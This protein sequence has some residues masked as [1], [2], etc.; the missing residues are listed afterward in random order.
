[1]L[2]NRAQESK[3]SVGWCML[4][5]SIAT[6]NTWSGIFDFM[7]VSFGSFSPGI[8][9]H[10]LSKKYEMNNNGP[11][12]SLECTGKSKPCLCLRM[13]LVVAVL[14]GSRQ[15]PSFFRRFDTMPGPAS[16][17]HAT[18]GRSGSGVGVGQERRPLWGCL[19]QVWLGFGELCI[20]QMC[21]ELSR[22]LLLVV[23]C[24]SVLLASPFCDHWGMITILP[25][26][27]C[28]AQLLTLWAQKRTT[29]LAPNNNDTM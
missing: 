23:A 3:S 29:G 6:W 25:F 24:S 14:G 19:A 9:W 8:T 11:I 7:G 1:M 20:A 22:K 4:K 15:S 5:C 17:A 18:G 26:L 13:A 16:W 2:S 12:L 10:T 28:E 21:Q 27:D